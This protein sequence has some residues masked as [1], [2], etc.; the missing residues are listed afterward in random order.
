MTIKLVVSYMYVYYIGVS[1]IWDKGCFLKG[2]LLKG[3]SVLGGA[4]YG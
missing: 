1:I 3:K 4:Y 2:F